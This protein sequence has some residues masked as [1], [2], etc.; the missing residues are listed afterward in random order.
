MSRLVLLLLSFLAIPVSAQEPY[1]SKPVTMVV[2]EPDPEQQAAEVA[3]PVPG[4]PRF[5]G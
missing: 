3:R 5:T 1:P 2:P 4:R